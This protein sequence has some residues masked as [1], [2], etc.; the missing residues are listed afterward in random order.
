VATA[1][2]PVFRFANG[3][4][5]S[6][7]N[8]LVIDPTDSGTMYAL[9]TGGGIFKSTNGAASWSPVNSGLPDDLSIGSL[10]IDP[11]NP[12]T[13]YAS[14]EAGRGLPLLP[15]FKSTDGG[16]TWAIVSSGIVSSGITMQNLVV[17][18]QDSSTIYGLSSR[19]VAKSVDGGASWNLVLSEVTFDWGMSWVAVARREG[20]ASTVYAGGTGRG[21]LKSS[22]GGSNWATANSGLIATTNKGLAIDPR[23]PRTLFAEIENVGLFKSTDGAASWTAAP[24]LPRVHALAIDP[25]NTGTVYASLDSGGLNKTVNGGE[26]WMPL[27]VDSYSL[28]WAVDPQDPSTLYAGR[29][30]S[31]DGG[32]SWVKLTVSPTA[33]AIDPQ[34]P[35]TLYAGTMTGEVFTRVLDVSTGILKSVDG[36]RSWTGLETLSQGY[37][38]ATVAVDPANSSV[39]YAATIPLECDYFFCGWPPVDI[40]ANWVPGVFRSADGGATWTKLDLPDFTSLLGIDPQGALYAQT[41]AGLVRS[42]NGGVTW[43]A[44]P[45][46]GLRSAVTSLAFDPQDANHLFAGTSGAGVFEIMLTPA[47]Q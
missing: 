43:N 3:S 39:V 16:S 41:S 46:A 6:G 22:D 44:V 32:A 25:Q 2:L 40:P 29:F 38:V 19:G 7:V 15:V 30:K 11:Q 28:I 21:V 35:A 24:V 27:P 47:Q 9:L 12:K 45:N 26:S 34:N 36:G 4:L 14:P 10:A 31:T 33:L 18:P 5:G 42:T 37:R 1:G 8:A 23:N 20:E 13:L 17:D